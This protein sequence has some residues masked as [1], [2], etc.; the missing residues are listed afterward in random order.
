MNVWQICATILIVAGTFSPA[1]AF[2]SAQI[3]ALRQLLKS[4]GQNI[5]KVI[6]CRDQFLGTLK[7]G[8]VDL[9]RSDGSLVQIPFAVSDERYASVVFAFSDDCQ[10]LAIGG[11]RTQGILVRLAN[12]E[13]RPLPVDTRSEY[14]QYQGK[15]IELSS[16][17]SRLQFHNHQLIAL[18]IGIDREESLV[19][20]NDQFAEVPLLTG[21][22]IGLAHFF[23]EPQTHQLYFTTSKRDDRTDRTT[24]K[25]FRLALNNDGPARPQLIFETTDSKD[26]KF[27][28]FTRITFVNNSFVAFDPDAP[29]LRIQA[30]ATGEVIAQLEEVYSVQQISEFEFV[31]QKARYTTENGLFVFDVRTRQEREL[32]PRLE[33]GRQIIQ[34]I[35]PAGMVVLT[36]NSLRPR[37]YRFFSPNGESQELAFKGLPIENQVE[38]VVVT[39]QNNFKYAA[40]LFKPAQEPRAVLTYVHGGGCHLNYTIDPTSRLIEELQELVRRGY[41]VFAINYRNSKFA[42]PI[43]YYKPTMTR[44]ECGRDDIEDIFSSQDHLKQRMPKTPRFLWGHSHGSY[45]VNLAATKYAQRLDVRGLITGAGMW[46]FN[47]EVPP[48]HSRDTS[49]HYNR[50]MMPL[51]FVEHLRVPVLLFHGRQDRQVD[52]RHAEAFVKEA[53]LR[54]L[55]VTPFITPDQAHHI[56]PSSKDWPLWLDQL[57]K[58]LDD[59]R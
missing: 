5:P 26:A 37:V 51:D 35:D 52:I 15:Q 25:A 28:H 40:Y 53:K 18:R 48:F 24:L 16:Y 4:A 14:N 33:I 30:I 47:E 45:L 2:S 20:F 50:A 49:N 43:K 21:G 19:L 8:A 58:F 12:E 44:E 11:Y 27:G 36:S 46:T 23:V 34:S 31:Y 38:R 17:Y 59:H 55:K 56:D 7:P 57:F 54:S 29:G 39:S 41:A 22:S 42:P 3:D 10:F 32:F 9:I 13:V 6:H 1:Q